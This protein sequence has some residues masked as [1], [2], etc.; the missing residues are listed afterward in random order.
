MMDHPAA[1]LLELPPYSLGGAEKAR[2]LRPI[3]RALGRHHY[4]A[5]EPYRHLVDR[6]FGGPACLE[7]ARLE[8]LP[9]LPV[10]LFK[11]HVLRSVS[12]EDVVKVLTSSGTT[13]QSPS[14][15]YLDALTARLQATVLVKVTQHHLGH[16]RLPMV[17]VDHPGVLKDRH[18][19]SARGAG[20]LGML[21]FGHRP[22]YALRD[23][24]SLDLDGLKAYLS[25]SA[26]RPVLFFGFTFMVWRHLILEL[27]ALGT[28]LETP[29]A[30]IVHSGGWKR[31]KD[32]AVD[33]ATFRDRTLAALGAARVVN[34]Y[35]MAEQ[36]GS[37]YY[38]NPEGQ[39]QAPIFSDVIIRDPRTL[40]PLPPGEPG[41]VEVVSALPW[42]YPGHAL[43]T[44]DLGVVESEGDAGDVR[45]RCFRILGRVPKAELRGCSDTYGGS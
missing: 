2:T 12:E 9:F 10:S 1:P 3:F 40:A 23:D 36:V 18:A 13:T 45:G 21:Q 44:E 6:V 43:L 8:D 28:H 37:V 42:S 7:A 29:G 5:C 34:F 22:F 14:R 19:F 31:L 15:I 35:G 26:G 4:D 16:Q 41:L 30:V 33:P 27:E 17:V 32:Q 11:S 20:I 24:M 39:L 25:Q 38:E